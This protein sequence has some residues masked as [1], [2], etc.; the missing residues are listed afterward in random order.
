MANFNKNPGFKAKFGKEIKHKNHTIK[1]WASVE[2]RKFFKNEARKVKNGVIVE[3][4]VYGGAS[5]LEI[6]DICTENNNKIYAIDPWELVSNSNGEDLI[7]KK[8][9]LE[10]L[11]KNLK[12]VRVN[13][14]KVIDDL[15]YGETLKLIQDFSAGAVKKF[16]DN[17]IDVAFIDGNHSYASVKEDLR[18]WLPKIKKG[19]CLWGDDYV[20][21]SVKHAVDD[22]C[23]NNNIKYSNDG[24]SWYIKNE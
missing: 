14:E 1:G 8:A 21:P 10:L 18:L 5:I 16:E 17:S 11:R 7:N 22:F 23:K 12:E 24:R 9:K 3:V 20:W 19:G 6:V 15:D 13:L 4:G 2:Q